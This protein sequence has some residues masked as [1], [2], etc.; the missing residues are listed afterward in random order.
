MSWLR[1]GKIEATSMDNYFNAEFKFLFTV[2][3]DGRQVKME[4]TFCGDTC[5]LDESPNIFVLSWYNLLS[6]MNVQKS[7]SYTIMGMILSRLPWQYQTA[8]G[9]RTPT[10]IQK[11][12]SNLDEAYSAVAMSALRGKVSDA[13]SSRIRQSTESKHEH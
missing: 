8:M 6:E 12:L 7:N 5:G 4:Q 1:N 9:T 10:T 2:W 3:S 13:H 11:L